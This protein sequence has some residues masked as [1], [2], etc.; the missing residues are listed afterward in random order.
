VLEPIGTEGEDPFTSSVA[1]EEVAVLTSVSAPSS[2]GDTELAVAGSQPGL[3][4]GTQD[5]ASCDPAALVAFLTENPDKATAWAGVVGIAPDG[6]ADYVSRLTPVLLRTDTRVTNHGFA[7][8]VA[9]PRQ[10]VLQAG[11]AVMVDTFGIPRVRCS[12]GNPLTEPAP[13]PTQLPAAT[14]SGDVVV[15]GQPWRTW[16]P[17]TVLVVTATVEV[18]EFVVF[19]IETEQEFTQPVGADTE[20]DP[21]NGTIVVTR[22]GLDVLDETGAVVDTI[23]FGTPVA[24]VKARLEP[25]VGAPT[26][27]LPPDPA[28]EPCAFASVW[29]GELAIV[30]GQDTFIRWYVQA[31]DLDVEAGTFEPTEVLGIVRTEQGI[32]LGASMDEVRAVEPD[33][34]AL[35]GARANAT[36]PAQYFTGRPSS[37]DS[38]DAI[39]YVWAPDLYD[40]L[41][42]FALENAC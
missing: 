17:D 27:E 9:T 5:E 13:L 10:S 7:D 33:L 19:D 20:A 39:T 35:Y 40:G 15:V 31:G 37:P 32:T 26:R 14:E 23:P 25:Y 12:C 41:V 24:D 29:W 22:L 11:T 3:Y 2:G 16:T 21:I 4:G 38:F 1:T 30:L 34:L 36:G 6:I 28:G 18:T 42:S 8:G